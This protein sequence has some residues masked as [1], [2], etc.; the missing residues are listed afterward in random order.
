MRLAQK[1]GLRGGPERDTCDRRGREPQRPAWGRRQRGLGGCGDGGVVGLGARLRGLGRTGFGKEGIERAGDGTLRRSLG[2]SDGDRLVLGLLGVRR[3]GDRS[4]RLVF[5]VAAPGQ[6]RAGG[7][8]R[9]PLGHGASLGLGAGRGHGGLWRRDLALHRGRG[10]GRPGLRRGARDGRGHLEIVLAKLADSAAADVHRRDIRD[11]GRDI[12]RMMRGA[13][14]VGPHAAAGFGRCRRLLGADAED[15]RRNR[16]GQR[17]FAGPGRRHLGARSAS[18]GQRR[19]VEAARLCARGGAA[20]GLARRHRRTSRRHEAIV[21]HRRGPSRSRQGDVVEGP[22]RRRSLAHRHGDRSRLVHHG[23]V[24]AADA[25]QRRDLVLVRPGRQAAGRG[26]GELG[27]P[28]CGRRRSVH[29]LRGDQP[30]LFQRRSGARPR[31]RLFAAGVRLAVARIHADTGMRLPALSIGAIG[32]QLVAF[33][34]VQRRKLVRRDRLWRGRGLPPSGGVGGARH[35]ELGWRTETEHRRPQSGARWRLLVEVGRRERSVGVESLHHMADRRCGGRS[36]LE[37]G[38]TTRCRQ[39]AQQVDDLGRHPFERLGH[40]A[41]AGQRRRTRGV[42]QREVAA[43]GHGLEEQRAEAEDVLGRLGP[44]PAHRAT[45]CRREQQRQVCVDGRDPSVRHGRDREQVRQAGVPQAHGVIGTVRADD[46]D[47]LRRHAAMGDAGLVQGRE[48]LGHGQAEV[49]RALELELAL[50]DDDVG[51]G[52]RFGKRDRQEQAAVVIDAVIEDRCDVGVGDAR[53]LLDQPGH[54]MTRVGQIADLGEQQ[55]ELDGLAGR[56]APCLPSAR[57]RPRTTR[58]LD[59][60]AAGIGTSN[61][62]ATSSASPCAR[63]VAC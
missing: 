31:R 13:G 55:L 27:R 42:E 24:G 51:H 35:V 38:V 7:R 14:L 43:P 37:P 19:H 57:V 46:L 34:V 44:G 21:P 50:R 58:R 49:Q 59:P 62:R 5:G 63:S 60:V 40:R 10:R 28:R 54:A 41:I 4:A 6:E 47:A 53:E 3:G 9:R 22:P 29:E 15:R 23:W 45:T 39:R 2:G 18:I 20:G 30:R 26:R 17:R 8:E 48:A 12:G 25:R 11:R 36:A 32:R 61:H 56:Q 1:S 52:H 33:V 16:G